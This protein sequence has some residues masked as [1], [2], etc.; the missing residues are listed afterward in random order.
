MLEAAWMATEDIIA[1]CSAS[2]LARVWRPE[3]RE[4]KDVS[5]VVIVI[6]IFIKIKV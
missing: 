1:L 5:G 6:I 2:R 4:E 3:R